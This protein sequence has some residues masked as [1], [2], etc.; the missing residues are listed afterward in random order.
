MLPAALARRRTVQRPR[1]VSV[2]DVERLMAAG[3]PAQLSRPLRVLFELAPDAARR[4][5]GLV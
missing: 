2:R 5:A 3:V 1:R 4:R